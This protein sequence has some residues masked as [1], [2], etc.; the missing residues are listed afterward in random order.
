VDNATLQEVFSQLGFRKVAVLTAMTVAET[1]RKI[2][3]NL[4]K[5][6][7]SIVNDEVKTIGEPDPDEAADVEDELL[8]RIK[9]IKGISA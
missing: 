6:I 8:S 4:S 9:T 1:R 5:N 2:L 3:A 7:A